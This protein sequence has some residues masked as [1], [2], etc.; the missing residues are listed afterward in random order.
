MRNLLAFFLFLSVFF[1]SFEAE[2]FDPPARPKGMV[3]DAANVLD[4]PTESK[5]ESQLKTFGEQHGPKVV[6]VLLPSLDGETPFDVSHAIFQDWKIGD[7]SNNGVLLLVG[8]QEALAAGPNAKKCGCIRIHVGSGLEGSLT[9]KATFDILKKHLAQITSGNFDAGVA[10]IVNDLLAKVEDLRANG[11]EEDGWPLWVWIL[12]IVVII[13][14]LLFL[15]DGSFS[16]GSYST[17]SYSSGSSS[18]GGSSSSGWSGGGSGGSSG[19][20]SDL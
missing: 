5:L 17:G 18:W 8:V 12:I 4:A 1:A 7:G 19:G 15:S 14:L 13:L 9:D 3:L 6:V 10:A 11:G 20:G 2:A 16:T